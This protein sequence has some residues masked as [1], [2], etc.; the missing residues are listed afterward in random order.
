M[1]ALVTG[2]GPARPFDSLARLSFSQPVATRQQEHGK[3][4][5]KRVQK[6]N[7]E[8]NPTNP[9]QDVLAP[10]EDV[11]E[12]DYNKTCW[13]KYEAEDQTEGHATA[14]QPARRLVRCRADLAEVGA[15]VPFASRQ[16]LRNWQK[17][18]LKEEMARMLATTLHKQVAGTTVIIVVQLNRNQ[19]FSLSAR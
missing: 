13:N 10:R 17:A 9:Q 7:G 11:P 15:C 14:C 16:I 5:S 2:F 4:I 19:T 12:I 3:G 6:L 1:C 8:A 18:L